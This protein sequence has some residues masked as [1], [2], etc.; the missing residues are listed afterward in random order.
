MK[1]FIGAALVAAF[2]FVP[3]AAFADSTQ[4]QP[5]PVEPSGMTQMRQQMDRLRAQARTSA[6]NS[7][8][9]SNRAKLAQVAGAL[10]VA[11]TPDIAAAAKTLDASLSQRES[12]A[13]LDAQTSF[14]TQM[15]QAMEQMR[16]ADGGGPAMGGGPNV[17]AN[18]PNGSGPRGDMQFV[19]DPL[20]ND[21]GA[22]L[23]RLALPP[24][25]PPVFFRREIQRTE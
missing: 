6:L 23:L 16:D 3:F 1:K 12:K 10:A 15:R 25:G 9:P 11:E 4:P 22:A 17:G 14:E 13:I 8:T 19:N 7:L 2:T 24:M 21:A 5:G 20:H 18:G